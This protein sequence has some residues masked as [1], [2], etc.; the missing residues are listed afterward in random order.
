MVG[1]VSRKA[2]GKTMIPGARNISP[3]VAEERKNKTVVE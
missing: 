3:I 1:S 2:E